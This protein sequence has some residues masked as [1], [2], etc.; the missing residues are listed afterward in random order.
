[1]PKA[2]LPLIHLA[3]SESTELNLHVACD[4][5]ALRDETNGNAERCDLAELVQDLGYSC[6]ANAKCFCE[7]LTPF[8]CINAQQVGSI[9]GTMA[10]T[11][12][13]LDDSFSLHGA[14]STAASGKYMEF[15]A[16]FDA[17]KEDTVRA[18]TAWNPEAFVDALRDKMPDL[19][20]ATVFEHLDT[21]S[22]EVP[23][24]AGL[25]ILTTIH[26]L[27]LGAPMPIT[28][29]VGPWRNVQAQL[30][31][32]GWLL[33]AKQ[34]IDVDWSAGTRVEAKIPVGSA[35]AELAHWHCLELTRAL[36]RISAYGH[37]LYGRVQGLFA[38][39]MSGCPQQ[40][41]AALLQV[42]PVNSVAETPLQAE[43]LEQLL[44]LF[45]ST[46]SH[47]LRHMWA[48]HPAAV[49]RGMVQLHAAQ[50]Q[51]LLRL[52]DL[53][54]SFNALEQ[55]LRFRPYS[56]TLDLAVVAQR[57]D[58]ISLDA[59]AADMLRAEAS[60]GDRHVFANAVLAYIREKLISSSGGGGGSAARVGLGPGPGTVNALS[61]EHAATLFRALASAELPALLHDEAGFLFKSCVQAK[62]K[63]QTL[64]NPELGALSKADDVATGSSCSTGTGTAAMDTVLVGAGASIGGSAGAASDATVLMSAAP[65]CV[66]SA[67]GPEGSVTATPNAASL[68]ALSG[69][70]PLPGMPGGQEI[71]FA[72][73]IEEEANSYFQRIYTGASSIDEV[74]LLLKRFQNS[75]N[76][77][78]Q[79]VCSRSAE[80]HGSPDC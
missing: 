28:V 42:A 71:H 37:E 15:D 5:S 20:W 75:G 47:V 34:V 35:K 64:F 63:L 73:G 17:D 60:A 62:P 12:R 16:K 72:P 26:R 48:V 49:M 31:L 13:G 32:L 59:W 66:T 67:P 25:A 77:R 80:R 36:L 1:M 54:Q 56:F 70:A 4:S 40:L 6:C 55:I 52:L 27:A 3:D 79:Q 33:E 50:P 43:M 41:L 2:L 53:A 57:K 68:A 23:S 45:I 9:V 14:F 10:R 24:P 69:P 11:A 78:E 51:S 8:D 58:L 18:L 39:A 21:P 46:D 65:S 44:P 30:Q 19:A 38:D 74:T 29:L 76:A 22:L 7:V 61:V